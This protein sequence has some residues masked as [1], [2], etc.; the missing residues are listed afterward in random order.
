M[1]RPSLAYVSSSDAARCTLLRPTIVV[2][3]FITCGGKLII[4]TKSARGLA[5]P[6]GA[7]AWVHGCTT[8]AVPPETGCWEKE[9]V[10]GR[11]LTCRVVAKIV[12]GSGWWAGEREWK[13]KGLI[14][15]GVEGLRILPSITCPEIPGKPKKRPG[16]C[17]GR[18]NGGGWFCGLCGVPESHEC[19]ALRTFTQL[20]KRPLTN[21]ADTFSRYTHQDADFLERQ[22]L[23]ALL[24][25][26]VQ[27]EDPT[28][29]GR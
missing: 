23:R 12:L 6:R 22:S 28:L 26:I 19:L 4:V 13:E 1:G 8:A 9:T 11:S 20:F 7:D 2:M 14:W 3:A 5:S 29:S 16:H 27:V 18:N 25:A 10:T 21:L 15:G 24:E 17:P